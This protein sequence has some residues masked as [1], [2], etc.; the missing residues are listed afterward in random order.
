MMKTLLEPHEKNPALSYII[1]RNIR[2]LHRLRLEVEQGR[3]L[4]ERI[5]DIL[6]YFSGNLSFVYFHVLWFG[7]WF[8]INSGYLGIKPFDPYPYGLLGLVVALEAI[9]LSTFLLI[10]QNRMAEHAE[11]RS[12]LDLQINLLAEHELTRVL[13]MLDA[14]H[15]KLGIENYR[16]CELTELEME[17]KP[18]EVLAEIERL[19]TRMMKRKKAMAQA[20]MKAKLGMG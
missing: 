7:L 19:Q 20:M 13:Q 16:D 18:E 2:T 12:D 1:D 3:N 5:A 11:R 15:D 17:T 10:S 8:L 14:I 4:R 6:T 9:F